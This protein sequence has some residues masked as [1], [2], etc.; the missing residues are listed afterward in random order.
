MI[1]RVRSV[2]VP[3]GLNRTRRFCSAGKKP[4]VRELT[5]TPLGA[6]SRARNWLRLSTAALAA[7]DH[8]R[9]EFLA[10]QQNAADQIQIEGDPPVFQ[11]DLFEA[12]VRT[13][14]D[15]RIIPTGGVYENR[16][17]AERPFH[18]L[19]GSAQTLP[20][21]RVSEK[22]SRLAAGLPD[23]L[24]PGLPTLRVPPGDGNA[25]AGPGQSLGDSPTQHTRGSA[26][27]RALARQIK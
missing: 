25:R 19:L 11:S 16:G 1:A 7:P 14:R 13:E 9:P 20:R 24:R 27:H 17:R 3:S 23:L 2:G 15:L 21:H 10:G 8:R 6:H 12:S 26:H 5:R 18:L 22:K 4:G